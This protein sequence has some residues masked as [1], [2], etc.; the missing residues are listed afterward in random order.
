MLRTFFRAFI[1]FKWQGQSDRTLFILLAGVFFLLLHNVC[2]DFVGTCGFG[3]IVVCDGKVVM[4]IIN[5]Q[6]RE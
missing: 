4:V 2:C 1:K 5:S 6:V 3:K